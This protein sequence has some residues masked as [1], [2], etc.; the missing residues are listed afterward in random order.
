MESGVLHQQ[1]SK[2]IHGMKRIFKLSSILFLTGLFAAS[3]WGQSIIRGPYLQQQS[4]QS[5]IVR[6]RTDV[7]TDSVVRYGTDSADL[8][9]T[10][11]D[12]D[13]KTEHSVLV[14]GLSPA[15]DYF[16][17]VGNSAGALAG[18]ASYQ[19]GTA[20][21]PGSSATTRIWVIGDSGTANSNAYAVRDA[22]KTWSA[23]KPADFMLMLGDNAY[24]NGTDAEYQSAVFDTY[25]ELLRQLPVWPTLGNH[26]GYSADSG[27]QTGPYYEIFDLP[28]N[29]EVGGHP[30]FTE[31]YYSF[32]YGNIHFVVLDSYDSDRTP[33]G[34]MLQWLESDL[35]LNDKPWLI[36]IWHHPP[37]TKGSH[38]SDSEGALID[39]RQNALP[40]LESWGVDLV[41]TG[42][43]HTYE[44]SYLV[45]GHYGLSGTLNEAINILD[46]GDGRETGNG[47]YQKP[48]IVAAQNEGSV[49][50][51]A[52]SS[53]K[54]ST[55]Y[56]LDHPVMFIALESLGSMV[57]D[58]AGNRLDA[59]FLDQNAL[60]RDE[61]TILKT[62]DYEAPLIDLVSAEDASH[63]LVDFSERV[64]A[65]G[66][67]NVANY[68][69][70]GLS[71]TAAELL[72]GNSTVR[73]STSVMTVASPYVLTVN[74]VMDESGNTIAADTQAEFVFNPLMTKSF[75]DN[76]LP[77]TDYDGSFDTYIREASATSNFGTATTLQVDGDEPSGTA[78]DMS[79]LLGW[80]IGV[81]PPDAIV[82]SVT[83]HLNVLNISNGPYFCYGLLTP[84][85]ETQ[86][87][88]NNATTASA[89]SVAG[90][91][92]AG[93]R[94]NSPLCTVSVPVTG[95]V[96][97]DLNSS[98]LALVQSWVDG[99]LANYGI[100]IAD[101]GTSD[102]A[103]F[104]SSDSANVMNRP[105]LEIVYT[106]PVNPANVPP[107]ASFT[108]TCTNLDCVFTDTSSDS[109]GT[110]TGWLWEFGDGA[111]SSL[112]SPSHTFP[113]GSSYTVNL[114]VTDDDGDVDSVFTNINVTEP[115]QFVDYMANGQVAVSGTINGSPADT[116]TDNDIS[117]SITERE[118]GGKKQDRHSFLE[119][120][121][122]FQIAPAT[123]YL[124]NLNA[125]SS[126]SSDADTFMFSWSDDDSVYTDFLSVSSTDPAHTQMAILPNTLSGTVYIRV[127]DTDRTAGHNSLD[128]VFIDHMYIRAEN[129]QGSPPS[130][131]SDLTVVALSASNI[132]LGW[133]DNSTDELGFELQRSTDQSSWTT[134]PV[135]DLDSVS[136]TDSGLMPSTTY[137]YR[138]RAFN[139]SGSSA[140]TDISSATTD[141]GPPPA[142]INLSLSG[143]KSRGVHIVDLSW[144]GTA[145]PSVDIYRDGGLL[146]TLP[147]NGAYTDNTNNKGGRSY[148]Y[149]VCEAD[150][151][152]CSA[153][154]TIIF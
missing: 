143:S 36:A 23:S 31:A 149:Q 65:V 133:I 85:E 127:V 105:K 141:S 56:P 154:E 71:I 42:H 114:T 140:W 96:A 47:A 121:W 20:P 69:I 144:S 43:S 120:K 125:W 116:A 45:D 28:T 72:D 148:T 97:V 35:A 137:Y 147:D 128:T 34:N 48:D 57:L 111:A 27:T 12:T 58:V 122:T 61:F 22:F 112:Q 39:M 77:N 17:S 11:S 55:G 91:N 98:G 52:G 151:D 4:D 102:G 26:D 135:A 89:W 138:L 50:A 41:L 51:V 136:A 15:T 126:G 78:T 146:V 5:I 44:R 73:L 18:D 75:Q 80:D 1:L 2:W 13:P 88:W 32:D 76:L 30:S 113:E 152:N 132:D 9:F 74:N 124:F 117:Q 94:D 145:T 101:S 100:V 84:W 67:E 60:V 134:L 81:I 99:S 3:A 90:A 123:G 8:N 66:A 150:T 40:I 107:I 86:A 139:L 104:D 131:P 119:H 6:W 63:V 25:P 21:V 7:A 29:A 49:Y 130:A 19:F 16:Y 14:S 62:P 115:P 103:D 106:V 70:T 82:Q 46:I 109:D 92:G 79:I 87:T 54:V 129:S 68:T 53:G 95:P 153:I 24:N 118:S 37:Y 10:G 93:D 110:L 108:Q 142:D 59:T 38:N 83:M 33:A 64:D